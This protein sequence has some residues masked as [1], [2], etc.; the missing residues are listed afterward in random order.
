MGSRKAIALERAEEVRWWNTEHPASLF[1]SVLSSILARP[2]IAE[3]A[4]LY[5]GTFAFFSG[6][7]KSLGAVFAAV[8]ITWY[9]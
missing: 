1:S 5:V 2:H 6:F 3:E 8:G 7:L 9:F 4:V